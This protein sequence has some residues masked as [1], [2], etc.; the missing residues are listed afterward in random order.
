[1]TEVLSRREFIK[2]AGF[3]AIGFGIPKYPPGGNPYLTTPVLKLGRATRSLHY[4]EKPTYSSAE[5]G[6]YVKIF[7][8][9]SRLGANHYGHRS[10]ILLAVWCMSSDNERRKTYE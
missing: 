9:G 3:T 5:L 10:T 2:L 8:L 4:Y 6:F 7:E 1:M